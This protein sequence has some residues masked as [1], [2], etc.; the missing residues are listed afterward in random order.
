MDV[1]S[2]LGFER[3]GRRKRKN[4]PER[5][6]KR[7]RETIPWEAV[8]C[9]GSRTCPFNSNLD[10]ALYYLRDLNLHRVP[11]SKLGFTVLA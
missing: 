3:M 6:R 5:E 8:Q 11:H 1:F 2:H 10:S 7:E 9:S 4:L